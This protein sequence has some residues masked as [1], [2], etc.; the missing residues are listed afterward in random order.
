MAR[1]S[2]WTALFACALLAA[3]RAHAQPQA[4][5][6]AL[7][8][9]TADPQL[10]EAAAELLLARTPRPTPQALTEAV[11]AAGSDGVGLHALFVPASSKP[12]VEHKWLAT[13]RTRVDGPLFCG[14]ADNEA[15]RLLIALGRGAELAPIDSRTRIVRG[16]LQP[17]FGEAELVIE[18]GDAQL[19]RVGVNADSLRK[20]VELAPELP[21]PL[22]IQ[23]V[24]R[25]PSGP[26]PVAERELHGDGTFAD[27]VQRTAAFDGAAADLESGR[28][29]PVVQAHATPPAPAA[30]GGARAFSELV[31]KLRASRGRHGLRSNR[32]LREAAKQHAEEVCAKGRVAHEVEAGA[33]PDARLA[34]AGLD[35]RLLGEAIARAEDTDSAL[36]ALQNSPSH[37]Y[38]LLD[39]RFTDFGIGVAKDQAEKFCY[40]VLLCAWPRYVGKRQ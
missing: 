25:G 29:R 15:G 3:E 40:V 34:K 30:D 39:P 5:K 26:R 37:L 23:L 1:A 31:L 7:V 17:G 9:C 28:P 33:G 2:S 18:D 14:R 11:R 21:L 35:A 4:A 6:P 19:L 13:L 10:T 27:E 16:Q 22:K 20:G 36:H 24:A 8:E 38:T 12:G 32:L